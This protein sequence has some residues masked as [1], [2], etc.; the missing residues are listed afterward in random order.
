MAGGSESVRR[1]K[2]SC[3][4]N[5]PTDISKLSDNRLGLHPELWLKNDYMRNPESEFEMS[6]QE[7][8]SK[9]PTDEFFQSSRNLPRP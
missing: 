1:D 5:F 9:S 4:D 2:A 3:Q 6:Y 7:Q 8:C